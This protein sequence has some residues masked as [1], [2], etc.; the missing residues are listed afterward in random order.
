MHQHPHPRFILAFLLFCG[1]PTL[2]NDMGGLGIGTPCDLGFYASDQQ[3]SY[4]SAASEC[5]SHVCLKPMVDPAVS[6]PV[7]TGPF[8]TADCATDS[9]CVGVARDPSN[10]S[11]TSCIGGYACAIP[12]VKGRLCCR[13]LC[14]CKDFIADVTTPASCEGSAA[15]TCNATSP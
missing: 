3:A 2:D 13:K 8:C 7:T 15:L 12:F 14:V 6:Q 10:P 5:P 4:N 11:D 9:D 1:C